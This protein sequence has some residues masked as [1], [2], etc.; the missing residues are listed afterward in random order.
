MRGKKLSVSSGKTQR[1]HSGS[2]A[3]GLQ[4]RKDANF[5]EGNGTNEE[6]VGKPKAKGFWTEKFRNRKMI[7]ETATERGHSCPQPEARVPRN[8]E[9][10]RVG[11]LWAAWRA[12]PIHQ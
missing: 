5:A 4:P 10:G 3:K 8:R 2:A 1:A 9:S 7:K 12:I 11:C 6:S